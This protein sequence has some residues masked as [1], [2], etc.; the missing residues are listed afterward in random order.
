[1]YT[2]PKKTNAAIREFARRIRPESA[3]S[4]NRKK[5]AIARPERPA[6]GEI[7]AFISQLLHVHEA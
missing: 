3:R 1:M 7:A 5:C 6:A 2:A 4:V